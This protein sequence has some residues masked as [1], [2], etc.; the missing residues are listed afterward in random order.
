[1]S[2]QSV[3]VKTAKLLFRDWPQRLTPLAA[4]GAVALALVAVTPSLAQPPGHHDGGGHGGGAPH[5]GGG[6]SHGGGG[7]WGGGGA[8]GGGPRGPAGWGRPMGGPPPGAAGWGRSGP[9][10][11][12][13]WD[14]H[15]HNGYW[16]GG[17]WHYGAPEGPAFESPGFRPGF[18]PWRRGSFLPPT[19]QDYVVG[20]YARYHLRRPPYGYHWVQVGGEFLLVSVTSGLIFDVVTG[21]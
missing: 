4:A 10:A 18:T 8:P 16:V 3:A 20:D 9:Q 19:Y 2:A 12:P 17:Q 15:R 7:G 6:W 1:V 21:G 14:P 13:G 11:Y 5:G